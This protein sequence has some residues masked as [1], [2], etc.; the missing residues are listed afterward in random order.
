MSERAT[1]SAAQWKHG[2]IH[3][4]WWRSGNVRKLI[5]GWVE[6]LP[7]GAPMPA[8]HP[9]LRKRLSGA[10]ES[11]VQVAR[12][13]M[14]ADTALQRFEEATAGALALP[15]HPLQPTRGDG[16]Q[17]LFGPVDEEPNGDDWIVADELPF[18]PRIHGLAEV[19]GLHGKLDAD[20]EADTST[21]DFEQWFRN[22]MFFSLR[23]HP[24]FRGSLLCVRYDPVVRWV[25]NRLVDLSAVDEVELYRVSTW[26]SAS[27][28]GLKLSVTQQRPYGI[29]RPRTHQIVRPGAPTRIQWHGKIAET[30]SEIVDRDGV[31]RW[32]SGYTPFLRQIGMEGS[33]TVGTE[34]IEVR[35]NGKVIDSFSKSNSLVSSG[36]SGFVGEALKPGSFQVSASV[37]RVKRE[38]R[39]R[40]A[41]YAPTW[42]EEEQHAANLVRA[43]LSQAKRSVWIFDPYFSSRG[44]L[45]FVLAVQPGSPKVEAFTSAAHLKTKLK[46]DSSRRVLDDV[47]SAMAALA[48]HKVDIAL[49]LLPGGS[50]PI[51]DRFIIVDES[52][53]WMSGNSLSAIGR[54][55][56]VLL[57]VPLSEELID[58]LKGIR[59]NS[60]GIDEWLSRQNEGAVDDESDADE[61]GEPL[62]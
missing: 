29:T 43:I 45:R 11:F 37:A 47:Q 4:V 56:S 55:A 35:E 59:A 7:A 40:L 12:F 17:V 53:A 51:H 39:E 52:R 60:V 36:G 14:D 61:D 31:V 22:H 28:D 48:A 18:L 33:F 50:H 9:F 6:L 23:E 20:V 2:V 13:P 5:F 15:T 25:D 41:R 10:S 8:N 38:E 44:L 24:E 32:R 21:N 57:E 42:L 46:H 3:L 27:T 34:V 19:R 62:Q 49:R 58:R 16:A 1:A 26:P 54:R 30:A